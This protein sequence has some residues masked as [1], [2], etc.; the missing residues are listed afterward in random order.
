MKVRCPYCRHVFVP[1][2]ENRCPACLKTVLLPGFF[3]K[4]G[5][6]AADH[7]S[8]VSQRRLSQRRVDA[9]LPFLAKPGRVILVLAVLIVVGGLVLRQARTGPPPT[10]PRMRR[11]ARDNLL[12][13]QAALELFRRHCET[14]PTTEEG[15]AALLLNP[16]REGWGG[17]YILE[18]KPDPWGTSFRYRREGERCVLFSVGQDGAAATDDD[19]RI[20]WIGPVKPESNPSLFRTRIVTP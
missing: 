20:E 11:L 5:K 10:E 14:Y 4:R 13:L 8:R 1:E 9:K 19:I 17:P 7:A 18:L 15:L 3:G 12:T 16:D 6:R 2:G